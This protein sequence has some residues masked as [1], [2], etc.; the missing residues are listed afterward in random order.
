LSLD[1]QQTGRDADRDIYMAFNAW[2]DP[3]AFRIPRSPNGTPWRR[4]VDTAL[5]SPLDIVE[6]NTGPHIDPG[7]SYPV[8]A[9]SL[10]VLIAD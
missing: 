8:Q 7:E 10:I 1:G 9:H 3:I 6:H 5:I 2:R 4:I